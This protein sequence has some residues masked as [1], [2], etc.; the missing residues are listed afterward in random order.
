MPLPTEKIYNA[1]VLDVSEGQIGMYKVKYETDKKEI[2]T[3]WLN[4]KRLCMIGDQVHV[5]D[6][7]E[8]FI[9]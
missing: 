4:C 7:N 9:E 5:K 6:G 3:E 1:E 8:K 2:K